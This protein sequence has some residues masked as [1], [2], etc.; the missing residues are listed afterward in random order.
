ME[1]VY[2]NNSEYECEDERGG[3]SKVKSS[4]VYRVRE[5]LWNRNRAY[6][7]E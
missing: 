6:W 2:R 1:N 5:M 7:E 3:V 4:E